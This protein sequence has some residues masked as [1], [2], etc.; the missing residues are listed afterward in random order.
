MPK[1]FFFFSWGNGRTRAGR[2]LAFHL[3]IRG[4]CVEKKTGL[5]DL[6]GHQLSVAFLNSASAHSVHCHSPKNKKLGNTVF[7]LFLLLLLWWWWWLVLWYWSFG[8]L[9]V[10]ALLS[11]W[12][13]TPNV[14]QVLANTNTVGTIYLSHTPHSFTGK[15]EKKDDSLI[16]R[17]IIIP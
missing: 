15:G 17:F 14:A 16:S 8:L 12:R 9:G 6:I 13:W 11:F 10:A 5:S 7:L 1:N 4:W 3:S 2:G